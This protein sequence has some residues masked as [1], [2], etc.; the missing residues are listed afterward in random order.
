MACRHLAMHVQLCLFCFVVVGLTRLSAAAPPAEVETRPA[1]LLGITGLSVNGR[2]QPHS[3]PTKYFFEY[4]PTPQ[5]G[6]R[7]AEQTL[8]P[9][10][11]AFY[12]ETWDEG[13]NGWGSWSAVR[14]H[15][16]E[17][18]ASRGYIRYSNSRDDHNHDDAVGTVHLAKYMYPGGIS[19]AALPSAFLS[20]GDPDFRDARIKIAVRGN[21]WVPNGTELSWW[22]QS[23]SNIDI[24]PNESTLHPNYRHSNWAYTGHYL[25]DL[26]QTGNW[27][28]SEYRL[29]HDTNSWSFGGNNRGEAR[30]I[31]WPI[32]E[33][34]RHLNLDFFHMV[35]FVNPAKHPTGSIDFDEFEVAY[36]NYSLLLPSNGGK[37]LSS[38]AGSS[39][40]PATLQDGWRH[41]TGKMWHSAAQPQGPLEFTYEF[42]SPVTIQSAQIHQHPQWPSREVEVL[43]SDDGQAWKPLLKKEM[44]KNSTIGPNYAFALQRGLQAPARQARV[45]I[46]SGYQPEHWGLGEIELFGTGAT[47]QTDDDWYH[48]NLDVS[49]LTPGKPCHYRLVATNSAGTKTG[50][51]QITQLP[52]DTKPQVITG[53]S[54]RIT[55][56]TAKVEGRLNPL[57]KKTQF[58]FEYGLDTQYGQKSEPQYGGLQ[59]VPRTAIGNLFGLQPGKVYHYRLVGVNETGTSLGA[60]ATF[61]TKSK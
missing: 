22:S 41:G 21:K 34:Q 42:D 24:N 10:L 3:L 26:L 54:S 8:P 44:P 36:R 56:T 4:G 28:R 61:E 58:Y 15:F 9:K 27:E 57:G 51:D 45:R 46:F 53:P 1:T 55:G 52:A 12:N 14:E 59:I 17:G 50:A 43:V 40:D 32:D 19:T 5:Y 30:Y 37:I 25:T 49:D 11:A 31:Y 18:G 38:P 60:D 39:T 20:A 33:V 35:I 13:W 6:H 47:M 2:I 48:V 29:V 16:K 7:T 23:Q